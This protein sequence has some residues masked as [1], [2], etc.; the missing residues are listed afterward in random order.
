V[1][2][3]KLCDYKSLAIPFCS[4]HSIPDP[5]SGYYNLPKA[6]AFLL[7]FNVTSAKEVPFGIPQYIRCIFHRLTSFPP[8]MLRSS[9]LGG[10]T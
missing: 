6:I 7:L 5:G 9:L 2:N 4:R 3:T 10:G 1:T 8:Y